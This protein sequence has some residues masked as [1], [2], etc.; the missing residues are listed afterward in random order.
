MIIVDP[1]DEREDKEPVSEFLSALAVHVDNIP[2]VRFFIAGRPEGCIQSGFKVPSLRTK[3]LPL[4]DVDSATT[5]LFKMIGWRVLVE[6]VVVS[7][8]GVSFASYE[9]I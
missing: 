3:E 6:G 9:S 5:A 7:Q 2:T 8:V 4:H 1:L